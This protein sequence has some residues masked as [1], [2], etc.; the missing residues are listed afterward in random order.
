MAM[1]TLL[2]LVASV[3]FNLYQHTM[4]PAFLPTLYQYT[5]SQ[6]DTVLYNVLFNSRPR[7]LFLS[8]DAPLVIPSLPVTLY[9]ALI[10][11][12]P[13]SSSFTPY[14]PFHLMQTTHLCVEDGLPRM[15][16]TPT[17]VIA[18]KH[19]ESFT[20]PSNPFYYMQTHLCVE[21]GPLSVFD[22]LSY[23]S[24]LSTSYHPLHFM[25]L[26]Q[27]SLEDGN[28][29]EPIFNATKA[30]T[31]QQ[32]FSTSGSAYERWP[33]K[34]LA[35]VNFRL[36]LDCLLF[37]LFG[38]L[39]GYLVVLYGPGRVMK[40]VRYFATWAFIVSSEEAVPG[41]ELVV[42]FEKLRCTS[43]LD[44]SC[45]AILDWK[46]WYSPP[47]PPD[48]SLES[49][50]DEE[51]DG[52]KGHRRNGRRAKRDKNKL[53]RE[54]QAAIEV[55]EPRKGKK[56]RKSKK[57]KK[58]KGKQQNGQDDVEGT[59]GSSSDVIFNE[60]NFP[61]LAAEK[62]A[63][64]YGNKPAILGKSYAWVTATTPPS[65][66]AVIHVHL[67]TPRKVEEATHVLVSAPTT[68]KYKWIVS[69]RRYEEPPPRWTEWTMDLE[70]IAYIKPSRRTRPIRDYRQHFPPA[71]QLYP[72]AK[73]PPHQRNPTIN[74]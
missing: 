46:L 14:G 43:I 35:F 48:P 50:D 10:T 61:P 70:D 2:V 65:A 19:R 20:T 60:A 41:C 23:S 5:A 24:T 55:V 13:P 40:R 26:D 58:G 28:F 37:S 27:M 62:V 56:S 73:P 63:P 64:K 49:D 38:V 12:A 30:T 21:D 4:M 54:L 33:A 9:D 16:D 11:I 74:N 72:P 66:K 15:F 69:S 25:Q 3:S 36:V 51:A 47:P 34:A 59:A 57:S 42:L 22:T 68:S 31:G 45:T 67:S 6:V 8:L 53:E 32:S 44:G 39:Y 18:T 52:S 29:R 71:R 7:S 1:F 17:P